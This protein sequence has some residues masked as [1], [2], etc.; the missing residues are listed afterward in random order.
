MVYV[1]HVNSKY[2][3]MES[4]SPPGSGNRDRNLGSMG[5]RPEPS[6]HGA[7]EDEDAKKKKPWGRP[8]GFFFYQDQARKTGPY[9]FAEAAP[10]IRWSPH[11]SG[12]GRYHGGG[13]SP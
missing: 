7:T 8:R 13:H 5:S 12:S 11:A 9:R 6:H 2:V 10:G 3:K 1:L 4:S